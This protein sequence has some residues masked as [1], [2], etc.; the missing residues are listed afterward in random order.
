MHLVTFVTENDNIN[1]NPSTNKS[2]YFIEIHNPI[3]IEEAVEALSVKNG[4][5]LKIEQDSESNGAKLYEFLSPEDVFI[6]T[7]KPGFMMTMK[8]LQYLVVNWEI[9]Y[10]DDTAQ[11][12]Y[13]ERIKASFAPLL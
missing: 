2:F 6:A 13:V 12:F 10:K 9:L 7:Q 8:V 11:M 5:I 1:Y 4:K 3:S